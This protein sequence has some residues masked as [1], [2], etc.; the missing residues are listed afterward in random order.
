VVSTACGGDCESTC[1]QTGPG[2]QYGI[3]PEHIQYVSMSI[4]GTGS[5]MQ[6][7]QESSHLLSLTV[8]AKPT[9]IGSALSVKVF[10]N[11]T[12]SDSTIPDDKLQDHT[13]AVVSVSA[14]GETIHLSDQHWGAFFDF[15]IY[16]ELMT[17]ADPT[18]QND[19]AIVT[20]ASVQR[21]DFS[22]AYIEA[23][24]L[25]QHFWACV[26][27]DEPFLHN[28]YSGH[29]NGYWDG[30]EGGYSGGSGADT[31]WTEDGRDHLQRENN[32][33][34]PSP[35]DQIHDETGNSTIH[36]EDSIS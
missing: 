6:I 10:T 1:V 14:K 24:H 34:Q 17:E 22:P 3:H 7:V 12:L 36:H 26:R 35:D 13:I 5:R 30:Y 15:G 16:I 27:C 32:T 28:F 2:L 4:T 11:P 31:L 33:A 25:L 20:V 19:W 8:C 9:N 23:D 18:K 29:V 21:P